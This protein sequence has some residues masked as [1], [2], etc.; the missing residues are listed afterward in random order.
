LVDRY[1]LSRRRAA[2]IAGAV[3]R[4]E[5]RWADI[6][7]TSQQLAEGNKPDF[8]VL[9]AAVDVPDVKPTK[10]RP[11]PTIVVGT[12]GEISA[13]YPTASGIISVSVTRCATLMRQR[14]ER[15]KIDL[16]EFWES[17]R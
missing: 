10:K 9:F 8:H 2:E 12:I 7:R 16:S 6:R 14:A 5:R 11:F 15:A 3:N 4:V 17:F 13:E 1:D